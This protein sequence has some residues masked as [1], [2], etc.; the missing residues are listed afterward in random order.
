MPESERPREKLEKKGADS[1]TA[2]ELLSVVLRT[3]TSGKNV[4]QLSGEILREQGL[5]KLADCSIKDLKE[6]KGIS[7]VKAS[8]IIAVGELSRRM[9]REERQ[10]IEDLEDA[11]AFFQDMKLMDREIL[12]VVALNSGNEVLGE[13]EYEGNVTEV[14]VSPSTIFQDLLSMSASAFVIAHNHPSGDPSSTKKDLEFTE[15]LCSIGDKL[16]VELLDHIILG[17]TFNSLRQSTEIFKRR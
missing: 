15:E 8:Q 17:K 14:S 16:G 11:A 3:G 2:V 4:K 1:L 7:K 13:K 12:R 5:Q 9:K 6:F 10:K